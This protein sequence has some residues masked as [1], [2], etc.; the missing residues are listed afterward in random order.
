MIYGEQVACRIGDGDRGL[1]Y[2]N[3]C[4][5]A[6]LCIVVGLVLSGCVTE[7]SGIQ[8]KQKKDRERFI[9]T[10]VSAAVKYMK[11]GDT[12]DA[13]R[14]LNRALEADKK[15]ASTHN[16]LALLYRMTGDTDLEERHFKLAIRYDPR[17]SQARNNYATFLFRE[18]RYHDALSQLQKAA[19]DPGYN[20][21]ELA[22]VNMGRCYLKLEK[23]KEAIEAFR[24]AVLLRAEL[25]AAHYELA[26]LYYDD[27]DLR[28]ANNHL[29]S[30]GKYARHTPVSL[31]LGIRIQRVLGD[32]D[33]LASYELALRNLYPE[34]AEYRLYTEAKGQEQ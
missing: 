28:L 6:L 14:H 2:L 9:E 24:R 34:S 5:A 8:S 32:R 1:P 13:F 22:L 17:S 33:A 27:G 20:Q 15:N 31:W 18:G 7:T 12:D 29:E 30:F 19:K 11:E 3:W 10:S 23:S 25:P 21:R 4:A 16:A 26:R